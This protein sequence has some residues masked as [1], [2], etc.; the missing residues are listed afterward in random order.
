MNSIVSAGK[1]W[2]GEVKEQHMAVP[3]YYHFSALEEDT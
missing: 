2:V 1:T 3:H